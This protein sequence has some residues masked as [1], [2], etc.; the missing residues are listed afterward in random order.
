M[1]RI[2]QGDVGSGKT[3][4]SVIA[5][6]Q[7]IESGYQ[8][9]FMAPTE[10]LARQHYNLL[11]NL[12]TDTNIKFDILLSKMSN[13]EKLNKI[14]K[15]YNGDLNFIVGTHALFQDKIKFK[16]LGLIIIDEQHKFGVKQR[17][18]LSQK[19]VTIVTYF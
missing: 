14:N 16:K 9:A 10:I 19:E 12:F 5:S 17:M 6:S 7:V 13:Y 8:V 2:I 1:F 11:S 4:V 3:I 15:I 18:K